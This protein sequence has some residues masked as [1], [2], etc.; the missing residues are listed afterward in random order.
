MRDFNAALAEDE[1]PI[2]LYGLSKNGRVTNQ[3]MNGV[4]AGNADGPRFI[5]LT[6]S[7]ASLIPESGDAS[8][9]VW[10]HHGPQEGVLPYRGLVETVA[11]SRDIR[12]R[13]FAFSVTASPFDSWD[14]AGRPEYAD[15]VM[16]TAFDYAAVTPIRR[17]ITAENT[18]QARAGFPD[19]GI[20]QPRFLITSMMNRRIKRDARRYERTLED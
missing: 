14:S 13:T 1:T 16:V 7:D 17:F 2:E 10:V 15:F 12:D 5:W 20:N 8:L 3:A 18:E 19:I 4:L 6:D 9:A 11:E